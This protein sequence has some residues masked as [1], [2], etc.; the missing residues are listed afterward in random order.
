MQYYPVDISYNINYLTH[1]A[2]HFNKSVEQLKFD[3]KKA[4]N[5]DSNT[6][7]VNIS[8]NKVVAVISLKDVKNVAMGLELDEDIVINYLDNSLPNLLNYYNVMFFDFND[9]EFYNNYFKTRYN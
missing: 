2:N 9:L 7:L 8:N 4:N 3:L 6:V 5:K 1:L